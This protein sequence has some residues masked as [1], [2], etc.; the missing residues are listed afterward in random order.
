[1]NMHPFPIQWYE[2]MLLRPQHFQH[3]H[4][5][6][7]KNLE[8][9]LQFSSSYHWGVKNLTYDQSLLVGE[10]RICI[11]DLEAILPDT[12]VI[13]HQDK[14]LDIS[15]KPYD[16]ALQQASHKIYICFHE[17][18]LSKENYTQQ[19]HSVETDPVMDLNTG[20]NPI[21]M[22]R[23]KPK[24]W[25]KVAQ[26]TPSH[27]ISM[28]LLEVSF[29]GKNYKVTP[30]IPPLLQV[31]LKSQLGKLCLQL[32]EKTRNKVAYLHTHLQDYYENQSENDKTLDHLHDIKCRLL[33]GLL[34]FESMLRSEHV[35]PFLLFLTLSSMAGDSA[36]FHPASII[37][38]FTAYDHN[39]LY[40]TYTQMIHFIYEAIDSIEETHEIIFFS[41]KEQV[42]YLASSEK[43]CN[44]ATL[45]LILYPQ[46]HMD[47]DQLKTWSQ[48]L[49]IATEGALKLVRINRV[50]GAK[51]SYEPPADIPTLPSHALSITLSLKDTYINPQ[52]TLYLMNASDS[53]TNRPAK[54]GFY[55]KITR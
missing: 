45:T 43:W 41:Q 22:V 35:T 44:E 38:D 23:L 24:I 36:S 21:P 31:T 27:C 33:K 3:N 25:L 19:Y 8:Y 49:I 14:G 42:F 30:Y 48:G 46:P 40:R 20:D 15:L 9:H 13:T 1:M 2:G 5:Y 52:E 39:N 17:D 26:E 16:D 55:Y 7:K 34:P 51:K 50:L 6:H 29:D 32:C 47:K 37:P 28:P 10:G 54:I 18:R 12:T 53:D 11:M 4:L